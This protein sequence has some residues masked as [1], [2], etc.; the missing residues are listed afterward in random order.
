MIRFLLRLT[1][2][3]LALLAISLP[4]SAQ[5]GRTFV[6][7]DAGEPSTWSGP[8]FAGQSAVGFRH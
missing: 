4:V 8:R 5:S 1:G 2:S 3:A 7:A 6:F